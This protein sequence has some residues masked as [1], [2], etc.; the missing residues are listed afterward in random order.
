M[1]TIHT[2]SRIH[3]GARVLVTLL[4]CSMQPVHCSAHTANMDSSGCFEMGGNISCRFPYVGGK[5][6]G[7]AL[8]CFWL[9]MVK[10][11]S[12]FASLLQHMHGASHG[13]APLT[14]QV[15]CREL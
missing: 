7:S 12:G 13:E 6:R 1:D 4:A 5:I 14:L 11:C 2:D 10:V 15:S 8:W 3:C 9:N